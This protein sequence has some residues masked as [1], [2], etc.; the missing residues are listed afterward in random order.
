M[1]G[2]TNIITKIKEQSDAQCL[3]I[4]AS[5]KEKADLILENARLE[6]EKYLSKQ[7]EILKA[8]E[9]ISWKRYCKTFL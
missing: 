5:A 3:A 4:T 9:T 2:L 8:N 6:A 1:N 7:R